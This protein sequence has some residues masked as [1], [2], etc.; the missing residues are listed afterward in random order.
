[1]LVFIPYFGVEDH[2]ENEENVLNKNELLMKRSSFLFKDKKWLKG[3]FLQLTNLEVIV[4]L[5][6][7]H[8]CLS[9]LFYQIVDFQPIRLAFQYL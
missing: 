8:L 3:Y 7:V 4:N 9:N 5:H 1:M 6:R 2:D